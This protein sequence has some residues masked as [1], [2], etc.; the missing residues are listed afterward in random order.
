MN[1]DSVY[2]DGKGSKWHIR[3]LLTS[4]RPRALRRVEVSEILV[5]LL[6]SVRWEKDGGTPREVRDFIGRS[7]TTK[8]VPKAIWPHVAY[9]K[10]LVDDLLTGLDPDPLIVGIDGELWDGLHRLIAYSLVGRRYCLA[11]DF[12][13]RNFTV[14][15]F[16]SEPID[17]LKNEISCRWLGE[18]D[19]VWAQG[20]FMAAEG[21]RRFVFDEFLEDSFAAGCLDNIVK[22]ADRWERI[23]TDFYLQDEYT[24]KWDDATLMAHLRRLV[25]VFSSIGMQN[26]I[27]RSMGC[28]V[29][30]PPT[31]VAHRLRPG[32]YI[33][34]HNDYR[35]DGEA[36]RLVLMLGNAA[37]E[38]GGVFVALGESEKS[39]HEVLEVVIPKHNRLL[40]F[41]I[42]RRSY[43]LVT[44][45]TAGDRYSIIFS[46]YAKK[47]G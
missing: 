45:V 39:E 41:C 21:F 43:H 31:V 14:D 26:W 24:L 29:A 32:D 40:S 35:S 5:P 4:N 38:S 25:E 13:R 47:F 42:S 27:A 28:V 11:V 10:G 23:K 16:S 6:D 30:L 1:T 36:V 34:F 18:S 17:G 15:V 44:E 3:E 46:Y 19:I 37:E 8:F 33:G 20:R 9:V 2:D 7:T 22:M 12:S